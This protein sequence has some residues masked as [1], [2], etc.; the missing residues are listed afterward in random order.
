LVE[1]R[2]PRRP[3]KVQGVQVF[4]DGKSNESENFEP[5]NPCLR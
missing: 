4:K 3:F 1:G 2:L 5:L